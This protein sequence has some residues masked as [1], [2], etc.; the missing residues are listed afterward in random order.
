MNILNK[1]IFSYSK[2][3]FFL[4]PYFLFHSFSSSIVGCQTI[5]FLL[6]K[7]VYMLES[8]SKPVSSSTLNSILNELVLSLFRPQKSF[9][10]IG[11]AKW[12]KLLVGL[13]CIDLGSFWDE[14]W[15]E[16]SSHFFMSW[17]GS[18]A[19]LSLSFLDFF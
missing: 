9:I 1:L 7:K 19:C 15:A 2:L 14:P 12:A 18:W 13:A 3:F 10:W 4:K 16:P 6:A 11:V 5:M 8:M 17:A